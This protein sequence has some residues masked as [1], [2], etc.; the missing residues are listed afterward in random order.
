M[1]PL[2]ITMG[3]PGGIGPEIILKLFSRSHNI[4]QCPAVIVGD[5]NVL[6]FYAQKLEISCSIVS[7]SPGDAIPT[8]NNI[9]PVFETSALPPDSIQ[10]GKFS[11]ASAIAMADAIISAVNGVQESWL[12]GICTCPIS[13]E[14]LQKSGHRFPGHTEM[15]AEL[16]SSSD[17]VMMLAGTSLRVTLA[18]I[19]CGIAEVPDL[20]TQESLLKLYRTTYNSLLIDFA[21]PEPRIAVAALNPHA[22]ENGMFGDEEETI[23]IPSMKRAKKESITL[24]GPFPPDTVFLKAS[25]GE[26]DAVICMYHD[27]GLIPLKLLHFKDGVNITLGL[28]IVRTSVDHGT[29]YDIAGLGIADTASLLA[30]VD[31]ANT[32]INN[33]NAIGDA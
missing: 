7:W 28:P 3:C 5:K 30:A 22:G 26:F 33:R 27:Q 4:Q 9:I 16:T 25:E 31:L 24:H 8:G 14:A 20:L 21:I 10:P 13:K 32:I 19:H 23:I 1:L 15:L 6:K 11:K 12:S 18:T 17:H 2:G 29:A